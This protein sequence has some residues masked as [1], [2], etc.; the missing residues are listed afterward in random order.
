MYK[1][2]RIKTWLPLAALL[3]GAVMA[4]GTPAPPDACRFEAAGA[5]AP[6]GASAT[7]ACYAAL[8]TNGD[9]AL[10]PQEA[11]ALPRLQGRFDELD[12][13][14]SGALS[15]DEFQGALTTPAQRGGGKGV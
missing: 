14:G 15:P 8:D 12:A 7:M 10:Q 5:A 4:Q 13:D 6:R 11:S 3:P 1:T 9:G 2:A